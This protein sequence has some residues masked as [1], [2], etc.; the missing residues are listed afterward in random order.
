MIRCRIAIE[1]CRAPEFVSELSFSLAWSVVGMQEIAAILGPVQYL[2]IYG[3]RPSFDALLT[4]GF[5]ASDA[6]TAR[7]RSDKENTSELR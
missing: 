7:L 2:I 5:N 1:C 4:V 6:Q 3:L